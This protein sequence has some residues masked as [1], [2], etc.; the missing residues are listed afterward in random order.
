MDIGAERFIN[1]LVQI[2]GMADPSELSGL[3]TDEHKPI[4]EMTEIQKTIT[5]MFKLMSVVFKT[6]PGTGEPNPGGKEPQTIQGRQGIPGRQG[7][8]GKDGKDGI[9]VDTFLSAA[10][11]CAH[12]F[13]W[14]DQNPN[15][16]DRIGMIVY[17]S[18]NGKIHDA[19]TKNQ[20]SKAIG[21]VVSDSDVVF[22]C[23]SEKRKVVSS[24][25]T[26]YRWINNKGVERVSSRRP[27]KGTEYEIVQNEEENT[28]TD[29]SSKAWAKVSLNGVVNVKITDDDDLDLRWIT[30]E[31]NRIFLR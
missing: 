24:S 14:D 12:M 15:D 6:S 8:K 1:G 4:N 20:D 22:N 27:T 18:K 23:F 11:S 30:L 3:F 19:R 7:P 13:E 5:N 25:K 26:L 29:S 10:Q 21:V 28:M 31:G 2:M 9:S 17:I 16:E